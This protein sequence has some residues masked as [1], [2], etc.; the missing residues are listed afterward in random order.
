MKEN[1]NELFKIYFSI[2]KNI[3]NEDAQ[4]QNSEFII[5]ILFK[6]VLSS[7]IRPFMNDKKDDSQLERDFYEFFI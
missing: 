2:L 1:E 7:I 6:K 4:I 3:I 5:V